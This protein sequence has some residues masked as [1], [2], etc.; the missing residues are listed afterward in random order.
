M[1][2]RENLAGP[3][4][5]RRFLGPPPPI[6]PPLF[7][8]P[9]RDTPTVAWVLGPSRGVLFLAKPCLQARLGIGLGGLWGQIRE[10]AS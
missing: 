1:Y 4:L 5:V 9:L 3:F 7:K 2:R 10:R 6:P 8:C